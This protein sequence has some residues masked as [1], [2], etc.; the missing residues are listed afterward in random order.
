MKTIRAR[1]LTEKSVIISDD[2][3]H[4]KVD[5]VDVTRRGNIMTW[6]GEEG[7]E[8]KFFNPMDILVV[9]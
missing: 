6:L 1:D 2:N 3:E 8:L 4:I 7:L 9:E 5:K